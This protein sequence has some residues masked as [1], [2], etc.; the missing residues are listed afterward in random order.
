LVKLVGS[1]VLRFF[2]SSVLRFFGSRVSAPRMLGS[3]LAKHPESFGRFSKLIA[4]SFS[5]S[6]P[7]HLYKKY[8][9]ILLLSLFFV[10]S[11]FAAK[12]WKGQIKDIS[13]PELKSILTDT[14]LSFLK[15]YPNANQQ[16]LIDVI[17]IAR[18]C[19]NW[20]FNNPKQIKEFYNIL[21]TLAVKQPSDDSRMRLFDFILKEKNNIKTTQ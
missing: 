2:G 21:T 8:S 10:P 3:V 6:P 20:P 12:Y 5:S 16:Q 18:Q 14:A 19:R 13:T 15:S 4:H 17:S 1:S 7:V 9:F 11:S